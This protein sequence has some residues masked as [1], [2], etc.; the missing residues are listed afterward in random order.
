MR[1][2][3][4]RKLASQLGASNW[5]GSRRL[6]KAELVTEILILTN[7][8]QAEL[9]H[10]E[11]ANMTLSPTSLS[12]M[13]HDSIRVTD[14]GCVPSE[15]QSST[16]AQVS[17]NLRF[18]R[19]ELEMRSVTELRSMTGNRRKATTKENMIKSLLRQRVLQFSAATVELEKQPEALLTTPAL[20]ADAPASCRR[21]NQCEHQRHGFP[22]KY[23]ALARRICKQK[24]RNARRA[25]WADGIDKP[26]VQ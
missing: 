25:R 21:S 11:C 3:D 1:A 9:Q 18:R 19:E 10:D 15:E 24:R 23:M 2:R 7:S 12:S 4:V 8:R 14:V 13:P 22:R 6:S 26:P 17:G 5:E 16:D 20:T